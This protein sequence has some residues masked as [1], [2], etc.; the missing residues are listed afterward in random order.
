MEKSGAATIDFFMGGV[1][2]FVQTATLVS[3]N[4]T[5]LTGRRIIH[6]SN[7]AVL[8]APRPFALH[9]AEPLVSQE[10]LTESLST[11]VKDGP[12]QIFMGTIVQTY[13]GTMPSGYA[14][15]TADED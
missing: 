7:S 2:G 12:P 13:V 6:M 1:L 5:L 8:E 9:F 14:D 15:P 4:H 3:G 11:A 10:E